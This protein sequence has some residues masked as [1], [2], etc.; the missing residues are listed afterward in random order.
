MRAAT[1]LPGQAAALAGL[2]VG[3]MMRILTEF[4]VAKGIEDSDYLEGLAN[5]PKVW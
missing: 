3:Q 1:R 5:L 4:G 2:R